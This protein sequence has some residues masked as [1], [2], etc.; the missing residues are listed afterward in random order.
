MFLITSCS[1]DN[2]LSVDELNNDFNKEVQ[3]KGITHQ[4]K[5]IIHHVSVGSNDAVGPGEDKSFSLV[6]NMSAD[7]SVKGQWVDG[8]GGDAGGI[9][10]SI[11]CMEVDGN[12]AVL[13]GIIT[14]VKKGTS[15][16]YVVGER[17]STA[18]VDNG[19]SS[20]DT[21]DMISYSYAG[22][23]CEEGLTATDFPLFPIERGQVVVR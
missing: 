17:A 22:A 18:V 1:K 16:F 12:S 7:G 10:V 14:K 20:N 5:G 6:A 13:G 2:V 11:D 4:K 9:H 19:T 21:L 23:Y 8:F 15:D 3:L